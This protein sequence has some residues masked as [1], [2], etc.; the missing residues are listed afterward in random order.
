MSNLMQEYAILIYDLNCDCGGKIQEDFSKV[1]NFHTFSLG[2]A[3][4]YGLSSV[5]V[6]LTDSM[7]TA[8]WFALSYLKVNGDG[9]T[10]YVL[11]G[12]EVSDATIYLYRCDKRCITKYDY[13]LEKIVGSHRPLTQNAWFVHG[14]WG[15]AKNQMALQLMCGFRVDASWEH[16]FPRNILKLFSP[17][18]TNITS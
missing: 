14:G 17:V 10:S 1:E 12:P 5:G 7:E 4:H 13:G 2:I 9:S 15:F 6:D 16:D 3:Q 11:I 18:E 8:L